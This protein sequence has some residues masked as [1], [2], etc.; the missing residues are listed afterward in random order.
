MVLGLRHRV[1]INQSGCLNLCEYGPAMII[2]PEGICYTYSSEAD[3]DE[4]LHRHVIRGERVDRLLL[5]IEP[6]TLH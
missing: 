2:Y 4:I 6:G 5:R 3:V 1:R